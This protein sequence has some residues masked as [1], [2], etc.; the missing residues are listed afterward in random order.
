MSTAEAPLLIETDDSAPE[1]QVSMSLLG[2][3]LHRLGMRY[4]L[5]R[6]ESNTLLMG[7]AIGWSLW[8]FL[9]LL[10]TLL[11]K[12]DQLFVLPM[13]ATHVRLLLVIPMFFLCESLLDPVVRVFVRSLIVTDIIP[14]SEK[15]RM[16]LLVQRLNGYTTSRWPDIVCMVVA[17]MVGS[18]GSHLLNITTSQGWDPLSVLTNS[19]T[20]NVFVIVELVIF[21]FLVFR[22][23]WR[24]V[25]WFLFLWRLS[26]LNLHLVATHSDR[27]GGLGGLEM[28]QMY[29]MPLVGAVSLIISATLAQDLARGAVFTTIYPVVVTV[30][31]IGIA[32]VFGPLLLFMRPLTE[33]RKR[34][35]FTYMSLASRYVHQF[36]RKW[37]SPDSSYDDFLGTGDLQS[38]ADLTNSLDVVRTM[39]FVPAGKQLLLGTALAAVLPLLP[40]WLFKYSASDLLG[41]LVKSVI[42]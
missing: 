41:K 24:L 25:L 18:A 10:A 34:G 36:E 6:G 21:R 31:A 20:L 11:G 38:L 13:I 9:V 27:A 28:V 19:L 32:M 40:L 8:V 5:V 22:W 23:S 17:L 16:A 15:P 29:F 35:Y 39:R 30:L 14:D 26:R 37:L 42:G 12:A 2:G 3:V 4:H 33:C 7:L 1:T